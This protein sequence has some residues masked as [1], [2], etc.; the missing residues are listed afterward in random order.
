MLPPF[1]DANTFPPEYHFS[2]STHSGATRVWD[3]ANGLGTIHE[4]IWTVHMDIE[5]SSIS[6]QLHGSFLDRQIHRTNRNLLLV[7]LALIVAV[8]GYA[9]VERRYLYNFF[10]GPFEVSGPQLVTVQNPESQLRYF[11]K[12]TGDD[13]SDTGLQEVERESEG[14]AVKRETVKAKYSILLLAKHLLIVKSDPNEG[15]KVYTGELG[16]IPSE[17]RSNIITPLLKEHSNANQA[18]LPFMMDTTS[19]RTEGYIALAVGIPAFVLASWLIAKVMRRR[20][21]SASHPIVQAAS[22]YGTLADVAQ[23]FDMELQGNTVRI[24]RA[25]VTQSWVL[26]PSRFGL[27]IC[28]VPDLIWAY[29]K[30]TQH[31]TNFIPTGKTYQV[32]MYD[33][34]GKPLTMQAR[35]KKVDEM[36]ALLAQRTPWAVFG[37]SAELN[38]TLRTNWGGFVAAVDQRRVGAAA[39]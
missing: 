11:V 5:S 19:F 7:S 38:N 31:R 26:L 14:G 15:G 25:T 1:V 32:I 21:D 4:R 2:L 28:R 23:Q 37:Y 9:V 39:K 8:V 10:S 16:E 33:R 29:K 36:L 30:V 24:G 13:S 27:S 3:A 22:R 12:V 6:A 20:A 17:V 35:Q 18:F 34:H